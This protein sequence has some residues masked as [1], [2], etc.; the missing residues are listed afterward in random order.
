[1]TTVDI[2][3]RQVTYVRQ[4]H[5]SA[6][7]YTAAQD[8][9]RVGN[10]PVN[11]AV[12]F[13]WYPLPSDF[14]G[15]NVGTATMDMTAENPSWSAT[16]TLQ[17][18]AKLAQGAPYSKMTYSN[19]PGVLA[20]STA[21]NATQA[22]AVWSWNVK[23]DMVAVA[24]GGLYYGFRFTTTSTIRRVF[25]G[26]NATDGV[27]VLHLTYTTPGEAPTDVAPSGGVASTSKPVITWSPQ[28]DIT[29]VRAQLA[30]TGATWDEDTG[31]VTPTFDTGVIASTITQI[32]LAATAYGGLTAGTYTDMSVWDD[33]SGKWSLP[34]NWGY[35]VRPS[36]ALTNP[37][38]TSGDP[39]APRTWTASAQMAWQLLVLD[40]ATGK[41]IY[42][43]KRV[44]SADLSVTPDKG[45]SRDGQQV[46][47][48]LRVWDRA[49]RIA[50]PGEPAYTEVRHTWALDLDA[51]TDP[52]TAY[53]VTQVGGSPLVRHQIARASAPDEWLLTRAGEIFTRF[54]F[55]ANTAGA[56]WSLD[57]W[58][59]PPNRDVEHQSIPIVNGVAGT[60]RRFTVK[61]VVEGLWLVDPPTGD[62][63]MLKGTDTIEAD[64][65]ES[66]TVY[67][68]IGGDRVVVRTNRLRGIEGTVALRL[69]QHGDRDVFDQEAAVLRM[70]VAAL[71][72]P[73]R[74]IW[75]S[76]NIPVVV[77]NVSVVDHTDYSMTNRIVKRVSFEFYQAGELPFEDPFSVAT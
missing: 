21:V 32:S 34:V 55:D 76:H 64:Y 1:M 50:T 7:Y 60:P 67:I 14:V 75:A 15:S 16:N 49:D 52:A 6:S 54:D 29:A 69:W 43:S 59:C 53:T 13:L 18:H 46:T 58:A 42:D 51:A 56:N 20:G 22:G 48:V 23:P 5:P 47:D 2:E 24:A 36:L 37:G 73:L 66:S 45:P 27:P 9:L 10:S 71:T 25:N 68:P 63:V 8:E 19:R 44:G 11:D 40:P 3:A 72:R 35:A 61:T 77:R 39:T 38:A 74:L 65:Q 62:N 4:P 26:P 30:A 70:K 41:A 28:D 12:S 17:R 33:Q 57:E 31:F